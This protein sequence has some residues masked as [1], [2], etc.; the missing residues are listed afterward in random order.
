MTT[1]TTIT[2]IVFG[3]IAIWVIAGAAKILWEHR[4]AVAT[5]GLIIASVFAGILALSLIALA[6]Y[7]LTLLPTIVAIA[8]IAFLSV[9][10]IVSAIRRG[11]QSK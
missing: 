9:S 11:Q 5:T 2:N 6:L 3:I 10:A 1:E 8:I 7:G 4:L